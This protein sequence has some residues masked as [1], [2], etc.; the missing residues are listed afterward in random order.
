LFFPLGTTP[1]F[2][3]TRP[4]LNGDNR[5]FD[6]NRPNYITLESETEILHLTYHAPL[7]DI[8]YV[9]GH[10]YYDYRL[11]TDLDGTSRT[12]P[13]LITPSTPIGRRTPTAANPTRSPWRATQAWPAGSACARKHP[14]DHT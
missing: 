12:D 8:R 9:G 4:S 6:A 3:P 11:Q 14:V 10:T 1:N 7:F 13:I 2:N 5:L